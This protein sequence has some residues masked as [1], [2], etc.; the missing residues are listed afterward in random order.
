MLVSS[1]LVRDDHGGTATGCQ[2]NIEF[3]C[4]P[5]SRQRRVGDQRQTLSREVVDIRQDA[6]AAAVSDSHRTGS[7][8][9]NADC[10]LRDYHW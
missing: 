2:Q 10:A 9:S 7:P 4:H 8:G 1:V 6:E 5:K 3:A